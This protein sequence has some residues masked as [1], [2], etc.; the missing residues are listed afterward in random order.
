MRTLRQGLT[1][2][3]VTA[4]QYFLR[5]QD[6]YL[7]PVD[8]D[9]GPK[10]RVA[11]IEFQKK[12]RLFA[13]GVVGN[14]TYGK[15]MQLGFELVKDSSFQE[16][17]PNWPLKPD[18][19]PLGAAARAKIFGDFKHKPAAATG[20]DIV[21]L[22]GWVQENI[23]KVEL[24]QIKGV[25]GTGGAKS[26]WFHRL[27]APKVLQLFEAWEEACLTSAILTWGGSWVPRFVRGSRTTLSNHCIGTA[28]DINVE[29]NYLGTQPAL[30]G[31]KGSVRELV[32][33]ANDLGFYWGGHWGPAYGGRRADGMHFELAKM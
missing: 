6:F 13:D 15:A 28:F 4:W 17:G 3:D 29:W 5:G 23:V 20:E 24:P 25:K 27:V 7:Y 26:F 1:G 9:F 12:H 32:P 2:K 30:V 19:K 33:I 18:F 14:E 8:G 16:W 22:D 21:I 10:T 31:K 11:T